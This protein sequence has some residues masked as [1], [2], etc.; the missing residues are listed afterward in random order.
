MCYL[1]LFHQEGLVGGREFLLDIERI[2]V[3]V[4]LLATSHR[5]HVKGIL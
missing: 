4:G 3:P 2:R 1:L 5:D